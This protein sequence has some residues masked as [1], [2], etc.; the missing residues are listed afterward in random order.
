MRRPLLKSSKVRRGRT[1]ATLVR[2]RRRAPVFGG[3][4]SERHSSVASVHRLRFRGS[5]PPL[6]TALQAFYHGSRVSKAITSPANCCVD[7]A[8]CR[9]LLLFH[10]YAVR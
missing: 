2:G 4:L 5:I 6:A 9:F 3:C 8:V 7:A 1:A 10:D